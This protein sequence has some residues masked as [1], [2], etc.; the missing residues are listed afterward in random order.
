MKA[1]NNLGSIGKM[2]LEF[3][4]FMWALPLYIYPMVVGTF[5]L[6]LHLTVWDFGFLMLCM[7]Y[8]GIEFMQSFIKNFTKK[9]V[10]G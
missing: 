3:T 5:S 9:E 4:L 7:L 8:F 2:L 6:D 10:H 1:S